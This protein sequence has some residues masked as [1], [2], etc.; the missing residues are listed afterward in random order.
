M[1]KTHIAKG[2][3]TFFAIL[4]L[5]LSLILLCIV[6]FSIQCNQVT[7][8]VLRLH[9]LASSD[10]E[11]D[12]TVKLL[13]RDKLLECSADIF[14][15]SITADEAQEKITPN[16]DYLEEVANEV[17]S[18]NGF[19]YTAK[20]NVCAEYFATRQYEDITLPAGT[21]TALKV[22]LGKGE[23]HNWWCVMFPPLC[24]PAADGEDESFA[25]FSSDGAKV[26]NG[27]TQ[28]SVR[29]KI[30]EWFAEIKNRILG[31]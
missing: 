17:L 22:V 4:I 6:E 18:E 19:D 2:K 16:I 5:S 10:S 26:V 15:G 29:F 28:Y 8:G 25:I 20:I 12:Q 7:S 11:E 13:V 14:D 30:V 27:Q 21:Y 1:T 9:I 31:G 23:G 3:S 24:L